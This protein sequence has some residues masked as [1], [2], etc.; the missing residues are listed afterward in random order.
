MSEDKARAGG[1]LGWI[2]RGKMV[3]V[4]FIISNHIIYIIK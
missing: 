1:D 2:L 3:Y 4:R